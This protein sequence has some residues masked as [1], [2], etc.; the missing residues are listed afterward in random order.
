MVTQRPHANNFDLLLLWG[1]RVGLLAL[2]ATPLIVSP[3][4]AFLFIVGKALFARTVIEIVFALWLILLIRRITMRHR[5]ASRA[6][7]SFA[8]IL[9]H[10]AFF[11]LISFSS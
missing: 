1:I 4:T 9:F 11:D 5:N 6:A 10:A 7:R 8:A 3:S 2:L